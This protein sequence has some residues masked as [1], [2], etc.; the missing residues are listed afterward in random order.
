M[1]SGE[2]MPPMS[3]RLPPGI[4]TRAIHRL[5]I[6]LGLSFGAATAAAD[7]VPTIPTELPWTT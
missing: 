7:H 2:P 3:R 6:W 1:S 5:L 4:V